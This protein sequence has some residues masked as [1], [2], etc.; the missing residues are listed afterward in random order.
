MYNFFIDK[1]SINGN[2]VYLSGDNFNHAKNVLRMRVGDEFLI[3][4]NSVSSLCK[5]TDISKTTIIAQVTEENCN[6]TNLH[7][8]LFCFV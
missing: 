6:Q 4:Y 5:I 1:N 2:E 7:I 3:S 8:K